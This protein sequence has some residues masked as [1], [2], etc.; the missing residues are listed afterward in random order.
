MDY[1]TPRKKP[2]R[3]LLSLIM[4]LTMFLT[5]GLQPREAKAVYGTGLSGYS[6]LEGYNVDD[7]SWEGLWVTG[8][9]GKTYAEG[10][11]FPG[12][13]R[14]NGFQAS[15]PNFENFPDIA[16]TYDA[17]YPIGGGTER[18]MFIDLV[19][20]IQI[21]VRT[22]SSLEAYPRTDG[23][24][25]PMGTDVLVD[26]AQNHANESAW[27]GYRLFNLPNNQ[28]NRSAE[29]ATLGEV[30]S[31]NDQ[32]RMFIITQADIVAAL[33]A[34]G[35]PLST[36][37]IEIYFEF[38][39][40]RTSIWGE[41]NLQGVA[42]TTSPRSDWGGYLYNKTNYPAL[43]WDSLRYGAGLK[44]G[45][46]G[47]FEFLGAQKS[48]PLPNVPEVFRTVEGRK[49]EDL[50]NNGAYDTGEPY[51]PGWTINL[52]G[53]I[54]GYPVT[55]TD[56]TDANGVYSFDYL[57]FGTNLNV[58][59]SMKAGYI[60]TYPNALTAD[61]A[62]GAKAVSSVESGKGTWGWFIGSMIMPASNLTLT[63]IDFGNFQPKPAFT[64]E[65]TGDT[66]SKIG[67]F[68]KFTVTVKNTGNVPLT[69]VSISDDKFGTLA[70]FASTLAIGATESHEFSGQIPNGASDPFIN[71]VTASY[72][73]MDMTAVTHDATHSTNLFSPGSSITKVVDKA[74]AIPGETVH[75]TIEVT[76]SSSTDTPVMHYVLTDELL[77][78]TGLNAVKFDL[79]SGETKTIGAD[80]VI[81]MTAKK[82]D[83]I[84]NT[85]SYATTFDDFPNKYFNNAS[86]S[87]T[88]RVPAIKI[89]KTGDALSKIGDDTNYKIVIENTGNVPLTRV[90]VLDI[91]FNSDLTLKFPETLAPGA[92][93]E[94]NVTFKIPAGA[95]DPFV[96][97][98]KARYK[99]V[100][101]SF[102]FEVS[103]KST[104]SVNL[105][106]P[107]IKIEKWAD[108]DV[109]MIGDTVKYSIKVTNT[110]SSDSPDMIFSVH[111]DI[112]GDLILSPGAA[113][114]ELKKK[115]SLAAGASKTYEYTYKIPAGAVSPI[116]NTAEVTASPVGFPNIL[117]DKDSHSIKLFTPSLTLKKTADSATSK[118]GD[119]IVYTLVV[120]N[121]TAEAFAP[122]ITGTL[123]DAL[124]GVDVTFT[125][126]PGATF[127][128]PVDYIVK[129][130]DDPD[131][132]TKLTWTPLKNTAKV[133]A[134]TIGFEAISQF[135]LEDSV[136]VQLVHPH[137]KIT[138]T[139]D[140]VVGH[141]G[142]TVTY[143]V[144]I[145]NTGD[146]KL[147]NISV[148]D[149]LKTFAAGDFVTSLDPEASDSFSYTRVLA[150]AD[151]PLLENTATV[152]SNPV[153]LPN[154]IT[155]KASARVEVKPM[156]YAETGWAYGG[157]LAIPINSLNKTFTNWGWTNGPVP[158][159]DY[160]WPIYVGAGL[161]KLEK[162]TIAGYVDV[163]YHAG[164]VIVTYTTEPGYTFSQIHLWVGNTMLPMVQ[165]GKKSVMTNSPG[166][167]TYNPDVNGE[168][169]W[170]QTITGLTDPVYIAAH[171]VIW[172]PWEEMNILYNTT[173]Y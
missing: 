4:A 41:R 76:N 18:G 19:K 67:D 2:S 56:V 32:E 144:T 150:A 122:S 108:K 57:T 161:N 72:Q 148:T 118:V 73:F 109:S 10:E 92:K 116:V 171:S 86:A 60:E 106:Q 163:S 130:A 30:G 80:Y 97:E 46:S 16:I 53:T 13:L 83:V 42:Y 14:L 7:K 98:V 135:T 27:T 115:D 124:L 5:L 70:G 95:A 158:E 128:L 123:T 43:D 74:F 17:T 139:V 134:E 172:V 50:N 48:V 143:T 11:W 154:V 112:V 24:A 26:A 75:Y 79:S 157:S 35:I 77:G 6:T 136:T 167:F 23:T 94:V 85:A 101:G 164:T 120:K 131:Y 162:G 82:D 133:T 100:S 38:H 113:T 51:L 129:A 64:I 152:T 127:T 1:S 49:F 78:W 165:N 107:G 125:L 87:T 15:F 137:I 104:H 21:G 110:G 37:N 166:Q 25:Y 105:F 31:V 29:T 93:A 119:K 8:N 121:T 156:L 147:V 142:D 88:V 55:L 155:D 138:K 12:R 173:K 81:P 91:T 114:D 33:T 47:H 45:S 117:K 59:E 159:G 96:N 22:L 69:L 61:L 68:I 3:K 65:K 44:S 52:T 140:P 103:D 132:L 58:K 151:I 84:T 146:V 71:K 36:D 63:G 153:D 111:D 40:A 126:A 28:V 89:T 9:L 141:V 145:K 90:E 39:L 66:L 169:T 20:G 160:H 54:E 34:M 102:E 149:T 168:T 62:N 170:S 99:Y